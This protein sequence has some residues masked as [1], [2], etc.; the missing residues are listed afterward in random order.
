MSGTLGNAILI[1]AANVETRNEIDKY[2]TGVGHTTVNSQVDLP[3]IN[4]NDI[5]ARIAVAIVD[6]AHFQLNESSPIHTLKEQF[7]LVSVI[8]LVQHGAVEIAVQAMR[9]GAYTVLTN[10]VNH[11]ALLQSVDEGLQLY[12]RN[13]QNQALMQQAAR[14]LQLPD[15]GFVRPS[16]FRTAHTALP[17]RPEDVVRAEIFQSGALEF[18]LI[19]QQVFRAGVSLEFTSTEFKL[20]ALLTNNNGNIVTIEDIYFHLHGTKLSKSSARSALTAHMS[21]MRQKL[22][23]AGCESYLINVRGRG[24]RWNAT[25]AESRE[26]EI[27]LDL[28]LEQLP[29]ILWTTDTNL[30]LTSIRGAG[31]ANLNLEAASLIGLN[32]SELFPSDIDPLR[33]LEA[34]QRALAGERSAYEQTLGHRILQVFVE[35]LLDENEEQVGCLSLALDITERKQAEK[36]L[37]ESEQRYRSLFGQAHDATFVLDLEGNHIDVNP[38][39]SRLTGYSVEELLSMSYRDIVIPEQ[40]SSSAAVLEQLKAGATLPVYERQFRGKDGTVFMAE[41]RVNMI[42]NETGE[43]LY[44]RSVVRDISERKQTEQALLYSEQRF[45]MLAETVPDTIYIFNVT[46]RQMEYINHDTFL[47]YSLEESLSLHS[48]MS[49]L[50]PEDQQRLSIYWQDL[51]AGNFETP[52]GIIYQLRDSQD[53]WHWIQNRDRVLTYDASGN[54]ERLLVCLTDITQILTA[55]R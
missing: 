49:K 6:L 8:A 31:L 55:D 34:H 18:D 4:T 27:K 47:G 21:N 17:T 22:R 36:A 5:E 9:A 54:P 25:A 14:L 35:S 1:V 33:T 28:L 51:V 50:L 24:Y 16:E 2:L 46:T 26:A 10:P 52:P 3:A 38:Q 23:E 43:P 37:Q 13:A 11:E 30:R 45:R 39:A 12:I 15:A 44:I 41:I 53:T 40:Q 48:L 42:W 19:H 7:P 32:L 29:V 20:V